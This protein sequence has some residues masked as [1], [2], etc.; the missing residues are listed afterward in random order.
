MKV[1]LASTGNQLELTQNDYIAGGGEG[2]V[3]GKGGTAFKIYHDPQKMIPIGKID[4]LSKLS[5]QNVLAPR[6]IVLDLKK[7]PIGFTM[8]L[9]SD[10]IFLTWLFNRGW[11]QQN[12]VDDN[13]IINILKIMRSTT[14]TLHNESCVVGDY[15]EL[16]FLVSKFYTDVFFVDSDSYQI[17]SYPCTAVM[18]TIRDRSLPFGTFN[19]ETDWFAYAIVTFQLWIGVHPYMC[20]HPNYSRADVKNFKM[21]EDGISA[22]SKDVTLPKQAMSLDVIPIDL[23]EWYK[24]IFTTKARDIPPEPG[25]PVP[26]PIMKQKVIKS[27]GDFIV[28]ELAVYQENIRKVFIVHDQIICITD[29]SIYF[30]NKTVGIYQNREYHI[31]SIQGSYEAIIAKEEGSWISFIEINGNIID[32]SYFDYVFTFKSYIFTIKDGIVYKHTFSKILDNI[33]HQ[34]EYI[35][36][37]YGRQNIKIF[38]GTVYQD[39]LGAPWFLIPTENGLLQNI[40]IPYLNGY[41]IIDAK[42]DCYNETKILMVV[43]EKSGKYNKFIFTFDHNMKSSLR[44]GSTDANVGDRANFTILDNKMLVYLDEDTMNIEI[45]HLNLLKKVTDAPIDD[46]VQLYSQGSRVLV[47]NNEKLLHIKMR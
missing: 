2:K 40:A 39:V 24:C 43:C 21:M 7:K 5:S 46:S 23:R 36:Q 26:M 32:Q 17:G 4:A 16:Q 13:I 37:V 22:F 1:I 31:S 11:K 15:N 35:D 10:T 38:T 45:P 29:N 34:A 41:R 6:D 30:N 14:I 19:K 33:M 44:P 3:Y 18:D 9:I 28:T 20:K 8:R 12:N 47:T 25:A 27:V 42:F